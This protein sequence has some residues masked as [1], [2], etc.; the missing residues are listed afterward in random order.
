MPKEVTAFWFA[1]T[2]NNAADLTQ[3]GQAVSS[4]QSNSNED[5]S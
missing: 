4:A 2:V 3:E 5:H 1:E